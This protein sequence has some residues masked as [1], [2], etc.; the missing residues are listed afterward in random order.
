[1]KSFARLVCSALAAGLVCAAGSSV[2][3]QYT[4]LVTIPAIPT[5]GPGGTIPIQCSV[6]N[7]GDPVTTSFSVAAEIQLNG[8][9]IAQVNDSTPVNV[10]ITSGE[11]LPVPFRFTI[12]SAGW[13]TGT[14]TAHVVVRR[15]TT[16]DTTKEGDGLLNFTVGGNPAFLGR[17]AYQVYSSYLAN[18]VNA[19]DGT[20]QLY[21][22]PSSSPVQVTDARVQYAVNPKFSPDG[23]SIVF[24]GIPAAAP[25]NNGTSLNGIYLEVYL[26]N[27][28]DKTLT[29]LTN[30]ANGRAEDPNFSPDGQSIV[31][32][33][34]PSSGTGQI[35][36]MNLDGSGP[37]QLTTTSDEKSAPC[38][39]PP[40]GANIV[41]FSGG[42]SDP[43][44]EDIWTMTSTG[45]NPTN[46]IPAGLESYYPSYLNTNTILFTQWL[47]SGGPDTGIFTFTIGSPTPQ[48]LL[49]NMAG[50]T[51]NIGYSDADAFPVS[52]PGTTLIGFSST[53]PQTNTVS[54][55]SNNNGDILYLGDTTSGAVYYLPNLDP[56]LNSPQTL[57][58]LG[59]TYTPYAHAR[60][61]TVVPPA[62]GTTPPTLGAGT[63][64]TIQVNAF[65]DGGTWSGASPTVVLTA[66]DNTQSAPVT[67][68]D[69]GT[70]SGPTANYEI[71]SAPVPIPSPT[72]TYTITA[73]ADSADNGLTNVIRSS[74]LTI[75]V[76]EAQ[77]VS[78]FPATQTLSETQSPYT[79]PTATSASLPVTYT[80]ISGPATLSGDTLTFTGTGTV[81]LQATQ[82]GNSTY[83]PYTATETITVTTSVPAT[84]RWMLA[85]L[86]PLLASAAYRTRPTKKA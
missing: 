19:T 4:T 63:T 73:T 68:Q 29:P 58:A 10:T 26:Y 65:S 13:S 47:Q 56:N 80:V 25:A 1:M 34:T 53:R 9:A 24:A 14:Y 16:G 55:D 17:I 31:Y 71:Y 40:N 82:A 83:A 2:S 12:P 23:S 60:K 78:D 21:T 36:R 64:A 61:L 74:S 54:Q 6:K 20:I 35:W 7:N 62:T 72:G 85:L 30:Y 76:L 57:S 59:G 28:A 39:S 48:P 3:A 43:A 70:G 81:V 50:Y 27:F 75:L 67:L 33:Q 22:L 86:V 49:T 18:P 8:V 32:K 51:T 45:T 77:T 69:Q 15:N 84:P 37:T 46:I 5:V 42:H 38:F 41:Y 79:L 11:T 52:Q 44:A 66:S